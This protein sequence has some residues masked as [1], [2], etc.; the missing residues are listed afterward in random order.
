MERDKASKDRR[1]FLKFLSGVGLGA[2]AAEVYERVYGIPSLEGRFRKEIDYWISQYNFARE[3]LIHQDELEKESTSAISL[4]QQRMDEA[5]EGLRK[6]IEKYRVL[7]GDERVSFESSTLK[8]LE[9]LKITQEK[10]LKVLPYFPLI[11]NLSFSPSK[12]INDKIYDLNVNLE[13]ISPLN[14]LK[15]VEVRLIPIEYPNLPKEAFPEEKVKTIKLKPKGLEREMF[16]TTFTD[17]KGGREYLIEAVSKDV[18]DNVNSEEGRTPY[19][20]EFENLGKQLYEKG[21]K[22]GIIYGLITKQH[23]W[24]D[25]IKLGG[26]YKPL[27]GYYVLDSTE[28]LIVIEKHMD[29][30]SGHGINFIVDVWSGKESEGDIRDKVFKEAIST[31]EI[32]KTGGMKIGILYES[33]RRFVEGEIPGI[34]MSDPHNIQILEEDLSYL[35]ENYFSHPAYLKIDKK[36]FFWIWG[37]KGAYGNVRNSLE[38]VY[39]F[40]KEKYGIRLYMV[41]DHAGPD[42]DE[43]WCYRDPPPVKDLAPLFNAMLT[44]AWVGEYNQ[45]NQ[46]Y[47]SWLKSGFEYWHNFS[48]RNRLDYIPFVNPGY[49]MKY[50]SWQPPESRET[51]PFYFPRSIEL[52]EKRIE[53]AV[54]YS[55]T[56]GIMVG[57]FNNVFENGHIEP[58]VQEGFDYLKAMKEVLTKY[59]GN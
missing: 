12:I 43:N 10:L 24:D 44:G 6:T 47:E 21:I 25:Y 34:N 15:E 2:I 3:K 46:T 28:D 40:M 39:K 5:I 38:E 14:T 18:A 51:D 11:K 57:D 32:F 45:K 56:F 48:L 35:T 7:L 9:D 58:T 59:F 50:C 19:I 16:D 30:M 23:T 13:V 4:Y 20:R 31:L 22:I 54:P 49:S 36:P 29:W 1:S 37:I 8:V 53:I 55:N 17:L 41:S 26:P 52:W 27:L 33:H 42:V